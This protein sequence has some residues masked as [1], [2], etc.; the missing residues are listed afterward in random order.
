MP[1]PSAKSKHQE[2]PVLGP[3]G[4]FLFNDSGHSSPSLF[5]DSERNA[6]ALVLWWK[7][8]KVEV[9]AF[10]PCP[11]DQITATGQWFVG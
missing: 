1:L 11:T 5:L 2:K 10:A 8:W 7:N 6:L 3:V 4:W 9:T